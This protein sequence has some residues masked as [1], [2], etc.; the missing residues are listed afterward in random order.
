MQNNASDITKILKEVMSTPFALVF[1]FAATSSIASTALSLKKGGAAHR[2]I[3]MTS[4]LLLSQAKMSLMN[5]IPIKTGQMN[6]SDRNTKIT[7]AI[8]SA[9]FPT[10]LTATAAAAE[11]TALP[12][13][14]AAMANNTNARIRAIMFCSPFLLLILVSIFSMPR[15]SLL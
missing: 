4:S 5:N 1:L 14:L 15:R 12:P 11:E 7:A 9:V 6:R 2:L 8:T 10:A 13:I 3:N